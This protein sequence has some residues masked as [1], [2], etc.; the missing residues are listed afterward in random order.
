MMQQCTCKTRPGRFGETLYVIEYCRLHA[1]TPQLLAALE[2]LVAV[3]DSGRASGLFI[4][5]G[6]AYIKARAAIALARG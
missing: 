2:N 1:A 3:C 5:I 4:S 6:E